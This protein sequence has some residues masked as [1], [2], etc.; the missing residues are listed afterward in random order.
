M[1]KSYSFLSFFLSFFLSLCLFVCFF[2]SIY[3]LC[4]HAQNITGTLKLFSITLIIFMSLLK[5][6]ED[7]ISVTVLQYFGGELHTFFLLKY[8]KTL[9]IP[10]IFSQ[11]KALTS[12][13]LL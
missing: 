3:I 13:F 5:A 6:R 7:F 1:I 10:L 4:F 9:Q 12:L 2:L 11:P 8:S